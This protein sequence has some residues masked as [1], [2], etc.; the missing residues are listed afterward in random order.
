MKI[1]LI[2]AA[3]ARLGIGKNN[4]LLWHLPADMQF[5]K[6]TTF[7]HIVVMGRKN[8]ESIPERFRPLPGRENA[9]LTRQTDFDAPGCMVFHSLASCLD[10]YKN[11]RERIVFIIG[12]GQ[13][14]EEAL[15]MDCVEEMYI[16]HVD[17]SLDADTF[18]PAC[19]PADWEAEIILEHP[20]DEKNPYAFTVKKYKRQGS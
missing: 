16:T 18:F 8:Y 19:D 7:G 11:E 6:Q 5:F 13:V 2:V 20:S 4:D 3:D 12:G 15:R 17:A 10:H 1:K 9:V 14:Y